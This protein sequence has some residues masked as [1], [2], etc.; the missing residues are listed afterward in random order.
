M[1]KPKDQP[2]RFIPLIPFIPV[3]KRFDDFI[4][5]K[6]GGFTGIQGIKKDRAKQGQALGFKPNDLSP[7]LSPPSPSS[8]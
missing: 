8:L 3:K 1:F 5:Q 6:Q 4:D 2:I 7:D